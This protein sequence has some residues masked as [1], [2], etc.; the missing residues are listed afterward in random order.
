ME[1][2]VNGANITKMNR[3]TSKDYYYAVCGNFQSNKAVG[4]IND[5]LC[6]QQAFSLT[7]N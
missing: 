2:R 5:E 3:S 4:K 1:D 6:A 7:S